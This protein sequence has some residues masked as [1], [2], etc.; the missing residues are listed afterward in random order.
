MKNT[1]NRKKAIVKEGTGQLIREFNKE[2]KTV[3]LDLSGNDIETPA[4]GKTNCY[5]NDASVLFYIANS[6]WNA[7]KTLEE[8]IKNC[9]EDE[10][11]YSDLITQLVMP[12]LFEFRHFVEVS[13]KA[14]FMNATGEQAETIHDL[15][16]LFISAKDAILALQRDER[17][18]ILAISDE[19]YNSSMASIRKNLKKMEEIIIPYASS[20][21]SVEYYRFLFDKNNNLDDPI[22][23]LDYEKERQL[24]NEYYRAYKWLIRS[25]H[26]IHYIFDM[27]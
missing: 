4:G 24:Q 1:K 17:P 26:E 25:I 21:P 7:T 11:D 9:F 13:L 27:H 8:K 3:L 23:T 19:K 6:Y 16:K 15:D 2:K 10:K 5:R 18:G 14:L 20:E 22:I 12:Y